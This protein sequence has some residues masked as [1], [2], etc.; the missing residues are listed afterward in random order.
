VEQRYLEEA[1]ELF[2]N[3]QSDLFTQIVDGIFS[4]PTPDA[5]EITYDTDA[6]VKANNMGQA[7][8]KGRIPTPSQAILNAVE[9]IRAGSIDSTSIN[10]LAMSAS[11]QVAAAT[12]LHRARLTGRLGKGGKG[13]LKRSAQRTAGIIAM[14]AAASAAVTGALD[15][16]YGADPTVVEAVCSRLCGI[17]QAHGAVHLKSPLLR[18]RPATAHSLAVG[19][20][21][22]VIDTRGTALLLPEDLTAQFARTVGRGGSAVA[23]IK[24]YDVDR[25]YHK[26]IAGGHPREFLEATFDIIMEDPQMGGRHIEAES[27]FVACQVMATLPQSEGSSHLPFGSISNPK[28]MWYLRLTHTRMADSVLEIC[29]VPQKESLRRACM[30]ILTRS[31]APGPST[32]IKALKRTKKRNKN[33]KKSCASE[34]L[35]RQLE[36]AVSSHGLP[37]AAS[38]KLRTFITKGC[39]PLPCN[40]EEAID[41]LQAAVSYLLSTD[42]EARV[43]PRRMKRYD[44]IGRNLNGLKNL[45]ATL[46]TLGIPP[47]LG[48]GKQGSTATR[49]NR[50]LYISLDLGL[51]QKRKHFHGQLM[52]QCIAIPDDYFEEIASEFDEHNDF[53]ISSA[54]RG[55]K[56]AE[57]GRYD[58]LVSNSGLASH[59]A[60]NST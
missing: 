47:L 27:V 6:A 5:I 54:G 44:D 57:G 46:S 21:V 17:F 20:P 53:V 1:L 31:C 2:T 25:I 9:E 16:V 19:G 23:N 3:S 22:E 12:A 11:S 36:N 60:C 59:F 38:N 40:V 29:G 26:A 37:V 34:H 52:F 7:K 13:M 45:V 51:R 10:S 14:R 4:R 24:R 39:M 49:V 8:G 48:S 33:E 43:D 42:K 30:S 32:L 55:I 35:E 56:V 18:P 28:P 41:K 50:P 15:G 58:D